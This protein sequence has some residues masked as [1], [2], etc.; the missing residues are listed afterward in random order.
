MTV[1]E[2][3]A[4]LE[5][6]RPDCPVVF[7]DCDESQGSPYCNIVTLEFG[8]NEAGTLCCVLTGSV[9]GMRHRSCGSGVATNDSHRRTH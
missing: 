8:N 4:E 3:K 2:L 5:G 6:F 1:A 9:D 7:F